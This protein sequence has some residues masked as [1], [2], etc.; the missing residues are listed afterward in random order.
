MVVYGGGSNHASASVLGLCTSTALMIDEAVYLAQALHL[1][2]RNQRLT[3]NN[4]WALKVLIGM[5]VAWRDGE[6]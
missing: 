5:D 4:L 3:S 1:G 6:V 2:R